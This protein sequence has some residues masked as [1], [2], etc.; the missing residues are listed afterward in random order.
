MK[1]EIWDGKW[2]S[3]KIREDYFRVLKVKI[4]NIGC[5]SYK[6]GIKLGWCKMNRINY[7]E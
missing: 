7:I 5:G 1:R 2:D 6:E 4:N 3:F